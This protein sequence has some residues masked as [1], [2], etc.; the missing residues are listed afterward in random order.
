VQRCTVHKH[1][2]LLAHAS[3]RLHAEISADYNDMI[4]AKTAK[5]IE[6]RRKS[7]I[8]KWRLCD[9]LSPAGDARHGNFNQLRDTISVRHGRCINCPRLPVVINAVRARLGGFDITG[10]RRWGLLGASGWLSPC[11]MTTKATSAASAGAAETA[12]TAAGIAL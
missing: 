5:E 6:T 2:N 8:R 10:A 1:R 11:S 3:E 7:F 9:K 12:S 4:Y